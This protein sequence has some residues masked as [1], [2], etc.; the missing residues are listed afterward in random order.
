MH[1]DLTKHSADVG[2][3]MFGRGLHPGSHDPKAHFT[4]RDTEVAGEVSFAHV[5]RTRV[6]S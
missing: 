6:H 3:G 2:S 1:R 4:D 5:Y